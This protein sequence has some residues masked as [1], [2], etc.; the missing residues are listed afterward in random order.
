MGVRIGMNAWIVGLSASA[1]LAVA[2]LGGCGSV[3]PVSGTGGAGG[4]SGRGGARGGAGGAGGGAGSAGHAGSDGARGGAGGTAIA[5]SAGAG[6]RGGASVGGQGGNVTPAGSGGA[7]AGGRGGIV[8]TGGRGGAAGSGGGNPGTGGGPSCQPGTCPPLAIGDLQAI[9]DSG[10]PGF[11]AA[12]FRCKSLTVCQNASACFYYSQDILGSLQSAEDTYTDGV[13]GAAAAVKLVFAGGAASQCADPAFSLTASDSITLQFD[14]GKKL[15]VYLPA[16]TGTS[17]T[18]YL[19]SDG[20]T[21]RDAALTMA[22]RLH[23]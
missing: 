5:G 10:A 16:F 12:G 15:A 7:A 18:L 6:G 2:A 8:A 1:V 22:A 9:D 19:A 4:E 11:D 21:F 20:S 3:T 17:L 14:G 13:E 23:P